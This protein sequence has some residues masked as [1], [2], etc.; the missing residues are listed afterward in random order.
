MFHSKTTITIMV[1]IIVFLLTMLNS[2][3]AGEKVTWHGTGVTTRWEQIEIGDEDGH[4]LATYETKQVFINDATGTKTVSV[5]T[6]TMDLNPKAGHATAKGYGVTTDPNGDKLIRKQEGMAIGKGH[7]KG[8]WSYVKG[9]GK[10]QDWTGGGTWES[11]TL[12]PQISYYEVI[13]DVE[14]P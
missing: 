1:L 12:A 9:T 2:A 13:G 7:M 6:G 8:T 4:V 11:W 5:S 14:M 3:E 10:Y